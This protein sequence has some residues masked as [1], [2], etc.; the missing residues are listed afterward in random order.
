MAV[1]ISVA[2][3]KGG[4]GKTATS[5]NLAAELGARGKKVLLIDLDYQGDSTYSSGYD[6]NNLEYSVYNVLTPDETYHCSIS[7]AIVKAKYYDLLPADRAVN[8]LTIELKDFEALKKSLYSAKETYDF[9]V[10]DCP[11]AIS[12]IT[13]NAF[14]ACQFVIIPSE[15]RA[16]SFLAMVDLKN[17]IDD[18]KKSFNPN[19]KVLG[20]L[21]VKFDKRT[22]LTKQMKEMIEDFSVQLDTS[23]Y[24]ATI[25]N[26]IAVEE[27]ILNQVP[28]GDYVKKHNNKPYID[29][30]GFVTETL[31]RLEVH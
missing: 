4:C 5:L 27:A 22:I 24:N 13:A 1:I 11:P 26:G 30:R 28:L 25:R 20:I 31:K 15:C 14:V 19:L 12:M 18:I 3:Q 21:L 9:I 16:Y 8:D 29:Y 6:I 10:I 7:Q 17:S 23:V 2:L